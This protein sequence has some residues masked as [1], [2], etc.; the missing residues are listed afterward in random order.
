[1]ARAGVV[2]CYDIDDSRIKMITADTD[3]GLTHGTVIDNP[4]IQEMELEIS[5]IEGES[6]GDGRVLDR[7]SRVE[8]VTGSCKNAKLS[9]AVVAA[10]M[11]GQTTNSGTTPNEQQ[12]TAI[13]PSNLPYFEWDFQTLYVG[14]D[15]SSSGDAHVIVH[16]CKIV[17]FKL[18][19]KAKDY[20]EVSF[21][22]E[23]IPLNFQE[24]GWNFRRVISFVE[25]ETASVQ[26]AGAADTTAPTVSSVSPS[27]GATAGSLTPTITWTLSE[28]IDPHSVTTGTVLLQNT[29]SGA[30]VALNTPTM[31]TT[32][33]IA[34]VPSSALTSGVTYR[35]ILT[36]GIRD[37]AG[38]R[39][40]NPYTSTVVAP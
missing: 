12:I 37:L 39:L 1:M 13:G 7:F 32:T 23:G 21:D 9:H 33:Q 2:H 24:V 16:K 10:I 15:G 29:T 3:S 35:P 34:A 36:T 8:K 25:N 19:R 22:W 30:L 4:G 6:Y 38:N 31:P 27:N 17:K 18:G 5:M 14:S 28:A 11:A 26:A 40:A 20:Q